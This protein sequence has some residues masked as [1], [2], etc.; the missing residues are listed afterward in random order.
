MAHQVDAFVPVPQAE[1]VL[2]SRALLTRQASEAR[3]AGGSGLEALSPAQRAYVQEN[4]ASLLDAGAS[5]SVSRPAGNGGQPV[6]TLLSPA[7]TAALRDGSA[8][9]YNVQTHYH[10]DIWPGNPTFQDKATVVDAIARMWAH[11]PT[12][13]MVMPQTVAFGAAT[14]TTPVGP[15]HGL[16]AF[17]N[18]V[19]QRQ[20]THEALATAGLDPDRAASR[21]LSGHSSGGYPVAHLMA[22]TAHDPTHPAIE[23]DRIIL[24]DT[25]RG[26]LSHDDVVQWFRQ[27]RPGTVTY[28]DA[29]AGMR[30][31]TRDQALSFGW[32]YQLS[33]DHFDAVHRWLGFRGDG[34]A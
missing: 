6:L 11:D 10:G 22:A 7:M 2:D 5:I 20:A 13:V 8:T 21:T 4:F 1:P 15:Q 31:W 29:Q 3:A 26:E 25:V 28:V 12:L 27:H 23:A 32:G 16:A 14:G 18:A 17:A 24:L 9:S 34:P 19:D 33:K 30:L